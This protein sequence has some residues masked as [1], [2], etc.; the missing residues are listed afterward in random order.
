MKKI[1]FVITVMFAF[2]AIT[3]QANTVNPKDTIKAG[4]V[5]YQPTINGKIVTIAKGD[6]AVISG[7]DSAVVVAKDTAKKSELL[8]IYVGGQPKLT[9]W[10]K[11]G[12]TTKPDPKDSKKTIIMAVGG[13]EDSPAE[14]PIGLGWYAL[15]VVCGAAGIFGGG[16]W[17]RLW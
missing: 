5:N 16:R 4:S 17:L 9:Q 13:D 8:T 14:P 15:M 3:V 1:I 10:V 12:Y 11:T 2:I 6:S 7:V